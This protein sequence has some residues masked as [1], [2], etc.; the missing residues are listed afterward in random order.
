MYFTSEGRSCD[1]SVMFYGRFFL[2]EESEV[3]KFKDAKNQKTFIWKVNKAQ[4]AMYSI[5]QN[6]QHSVKN[7]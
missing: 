1:S 7:S 3:L 6:Y 4:D 5:E 2:N